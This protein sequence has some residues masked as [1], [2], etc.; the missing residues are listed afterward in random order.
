MNALFR[1]K[2][3]LSVIVF[4]FN[5]NISLCSDFAD[6]QRDVIPKSYPLFLLEYNGQEVGDKTSSE[7]Q[8]RAQDFVRPCAR[9]DQPCKARK[10]DCG[11]FLSLNF[12]SQFEWTAFNGK[13]NS[14]NGFDGLYKVSIDPDIYLVV[15]DKAGESSLNRKNNQM[16]LQWQSVTA[17]KLAASNYKNELEKFTIEENVNFQSALYKGNVIGLL[18][19]TFYEEVEEFNGNRYSE[20]SPIYNFF[21]Q[22]YLLGSCYWPQNF[23]MN[24]TYTF[25]NYI[26]PVLSNLPIHN[27]EER[28]S[29]LAYNLSWNNEGIS[30]TESKNRK[31]SLNKKGCL[32][33]RILN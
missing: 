10:G 6:E 20:T 15:E 11:E 8:C 24:Y 25:K 17:D 33:K 7:N 13:Y 14:I 32:F 19:K 4:L 5:F 23:Q 22:F 31:I 18:T 2:I 21:T 28:E 9:T 16:S 30:R 12:T 3:F 29:P 1:D 27:L 26:Y